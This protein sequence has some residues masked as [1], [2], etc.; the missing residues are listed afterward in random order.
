MKKII[1]L[2]CALFLGGCTAKFAYNNVSWLVYWYLDDYIEL[3]NEQEDQFDVMLDNWMTWHRN[4]ELPRYQAQLDDI[5]YD[6]QSNNINE[7]SIRSHRE[8]AKQHWVRARTH[9]APDLVSLGTNL[10]PEQ[11]E[12]FFSNL[13]KKNKD[14]EEEIV[15]RKELPEREQIKKWTKRNQ[16]GIKKWIGKLSDEQKQIIASFHN[17]FEATGLH[18]LAYQREYQRQLK[19]VFAHPDRGEIFKQS[20]HALIVDPEKFRSPSFQLMIDTNAHAS[21][22][23]MKGIFSLMSAKQ[24]ENLIEEIEELREDIVKLQKKAV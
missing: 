11:I 20:L 15:E 2:V 4:E 23:Y 13:E 5:I 7:Q 19:D 17:E 1:V 9:L 6:I 24:I 8:R 10:S 12:Q 22:E 14:E 21:A 3:N 18:W 16:K